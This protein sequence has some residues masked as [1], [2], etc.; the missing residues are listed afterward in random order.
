VYREYNISSGS[1]A[2]IRRLALFTASQQQG[3]LKSKLLLGVL[4]WIY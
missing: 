4:H 1:T 3:L 2:T